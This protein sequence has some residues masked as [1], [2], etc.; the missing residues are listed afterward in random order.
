MIFVARLSVH[1]RSG[2]S[3]RCIRFEQTARRLQVPTKIGV[4]RRELGSA[5]ITQPSTRLTE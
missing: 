3:T 4:S 1:Y 5:V 2:F